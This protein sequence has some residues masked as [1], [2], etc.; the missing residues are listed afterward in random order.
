MT[1]WK[2]SRRAPRSSVGRAGREKRV[3]NQ[4]VMAVKL[5]IETAKE[6]SR[7]RGERELCLYSCVIRAHASR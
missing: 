5:Q 2:W 6:A 4:V 7:V 3:V 1:R